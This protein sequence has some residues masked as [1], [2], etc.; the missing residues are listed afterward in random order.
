M[1]TSI[2]S[3]LAYLIDRQ[4]LTAEEIKQIVIKTEQEIES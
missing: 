3:A 1:K 2:L 4:A